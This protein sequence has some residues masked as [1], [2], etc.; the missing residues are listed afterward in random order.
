MKLLKRILIFS[1][2][3]LMAFALLSACSKDEQGEKDNHEHKSADNEWQVDIENHWKICSEDNEK[4]ENGAHALENNICTV[5]GV[6]VTETGDGTGELCFYNENGDWSRLI[7]YNEDGTYVTETAEYT[8]DENDNKLTM[9]TYKDGKPVLETEYGTN[10]DG[11]STELKNT[12]YDEDGSKKVYIYNL[13]NDI[14]NELDYNA[15]GTVERELVIEYTYNE[16][17]EKELEKHTLNGK[18][19]KEVKYFVFS[20]D[21]WGGK[22]WYSEVTEHNEDG[23]TT[24]NTYDENGEPVVTE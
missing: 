9:K 15:D 20:A 13:K 18:L 8:Y 12:I 23:T 3:C 10:E 17:G 2:V 4:F 6:Q 11:Y 16:N 14:T 21:S 5:C 7:T 22:I 24:V 19:V 1:L